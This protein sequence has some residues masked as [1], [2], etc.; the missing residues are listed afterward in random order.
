M[1]KEDVMGLSDIK[2]LRELTSLGINECRKALA[3]AEGNF[4]KALGILKNRGVQMLE[5]KSSRTAS[6]GIIDSYIHFGGNLGALVEVNCETDFV[7]RT[8]VFKKFVKDVAMQVAA[9]Y[10]EYIGKADVP[11]DVLKKQENSEE[12]LK[13]ACLLEQPFIKDN[14]LTVG[15]YLRDVVSQTGENVV[16]KRFVR[17]SLGD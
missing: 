5:K 8:E 2:K 14:Q 9:V 12:Y 17:F 1:N 15:Q 3:Q 11:E 6:Q 4:D 16:I 7:A 10:P 13:Q